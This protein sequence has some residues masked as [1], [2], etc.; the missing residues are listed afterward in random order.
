MCRALVLCGHSGLRYSFEGAPKTLTTVGRAY[1][2]TAAA[3]SE[4]GHRGEFLRVQNDGR[5][6]VSE[7]ALPPAS[8]SGCTTP[9]LA[10]KLDD[11]SAKRSAHS[12]SSS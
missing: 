4:R 8:T 1:E 6:S 7:A 2:P 12:S 10:A 5:A 9:V 11:T 3:G